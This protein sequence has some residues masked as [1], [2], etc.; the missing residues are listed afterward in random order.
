MDKQ[1]LREEYKKAHIFVLPSLYEGM[2]NS[3]LE[4][5]SCGCM[6]IVSDIPGSRELVKGCK[7]GFVFNVGDSS[8]LKDILITALSRDVAA[9]E[10]MGRQSRAIAQGFDWNKVSDLYIKEF[11]A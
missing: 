5:M 6:A 8:S 4:A 2:S 10:E 3:L 1:K 7:N 11:Y 9:I